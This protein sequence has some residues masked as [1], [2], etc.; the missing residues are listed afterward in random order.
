[1]KIL[2]NIFSGIKDVL[3]AN[4]IPN[5]AKLY[6]LAGLAHAHPE[7]KITVAADN[8][9]NIS[10]ISQAASK[11]GATLY[12]LVEVDVGMKRCGVNTPDEVHAL[13]K[14]IMDSKGLVFEGIQAYEGHLVYDLD[15]PTCGLCM[16][17]LPCSL[18]N[19]VNR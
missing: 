16:L 9:D 14:K 3:I 4:E 15:I 6:R 10:A 7:T 2:S 13:A 19:P 1:M 5:P 18:E 11:F 8:A 12:V 17:K